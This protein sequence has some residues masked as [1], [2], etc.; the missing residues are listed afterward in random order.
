MLYPN[1]HFHSVGEVQ[2]RADVDRCLRSA[3]DFGAPVYGGTDVAPIRSRV[4]RSEVWPRAPGGW[5]DRGSGL[6]W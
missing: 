1:A 2:A 3:K 5:S 4:G 6:I